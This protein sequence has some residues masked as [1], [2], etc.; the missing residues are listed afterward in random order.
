MAQKDAVSN[1]YVVDESAWS[2]GPARLSERELEFVRR[3]QI[4]LG[5][6]KPCSACHRRLL[7]GQFDVGRARC[8]RCERELGLERW[9]TEHKRSVG[10]I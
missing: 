8:R 1:A 9:W 10:I 5:A 4:A 6:V 7:V 2:S 3:W